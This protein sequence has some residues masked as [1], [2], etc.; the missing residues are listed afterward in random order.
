MGAACCVAAKDA[1]ITNRSTSEALQR[2]GRYSPSWSFQW[3]NHG[4][5][6]VEETSMNLISDGVSRNGLEIKSGT[7]IETAYASEEGSPVDSLRTLTWQK[8]PISE[9]NSEMLRPPLTDQ[10]NSRKF[11]SEVKESTES[12]TVFEPSPTKLSSSVHSVSSTFAS[13]LSSRSHLLPASSTPLQW[14]LHSPGHPLLRQVSDSRL[15]GHKSRNLSISD[16]SSFL[17]PG[18]SNES[19]RGS[20]GGSSDSW[21]IPTLPEFMAPPHRERW[22][23]DSESFG[24]LTDKITRSSSQLSASS[25]VDM[26][27]CGVC[28]RL[29]TEKS[30]WSSQKLISNNEL[31]VV[32]I[33]ICGHVYHAECLESMTPEFNKYDPACP[34]CTFGEKQAQKLLDKALKAEMSLKI[35]NKRSRNRIVNSDLDSDSIMIVGQK[36]RGKE[37]EDLKRVSSPSMKNALGK[38]LLRRHF[39]FGSKGTRSSS[40]NQTTQK[41]GFFWSKSSKARVAF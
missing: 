39:S 13:P 41:K 5:V 14:P 17:F 33:L 35:K 15:P 25:P 37:G 9:R 30:S 11:P 3:D 12:L 21:S 4:R 24:F 27:T 36:D 2:N 28:S 40:E 8:S 34:V 23:L 18:W 7:T 32:A 29:L 16:E 20:I 38:P 19:T 26:Q 10:S 6:A 1:T 22:S 31:P